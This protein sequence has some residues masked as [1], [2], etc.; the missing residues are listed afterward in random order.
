MG[1]DLPAQVSAISV[2]AEHPRC[3]T[4]TGGP[5]GPLYAWEEPK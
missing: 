3:G 1:S 4:L 2:L 5:W